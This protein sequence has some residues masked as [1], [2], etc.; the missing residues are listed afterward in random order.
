MKIIK[1]K[2]TSKLQKYGDAIEAKIA[3]DRNRHCFA[4]YNMECKAK[5]Y[6]DLCFKDELTK[7]KTETKCIFQK[8]KYWVLE[9]IVQVHSFNSVLVYTHLTINL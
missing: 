1:Q 7:T 5:G 4:I 8:G 2:C 3:C 6:Y 9:E